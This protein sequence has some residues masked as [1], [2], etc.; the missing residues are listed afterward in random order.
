[1]I[2]IGGHKDL[3][4]KNLRKKL[5]I[6]QDFRV[7]DCTGDSSIFDGFSVEEL[8]TL[9][10]TDQL[11]D[12]DTI[13][14]IATRREIERMEEARRNYFGSLD[15]RH[16]TFSILTAY[17]KKDGKLNIFIVLKQKAYK[18]LGKDLVD[19]MRKISGNDD[20]VNTWSEIEDDYERALTWV[21][22]D[23][24]LADIKNSVKNELREEEEP[25]TKYGWKHGGKKKYSSDGDDDD[26]EMN[27]RRR[28][29]LERKEQKKLLKRM[30]GHNYTIF[31]DMDRVFGFDSKTKSYT[32]DL[33]D[34]DY[35]T[36]G[37]IHKKKKKKNWTDE[38]P[39]FL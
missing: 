20:I 34:A 31:D 21:P 3:S 33:L 17:L 39:K 12:M 9:T 6:L 32:E 30:L 27:E 22:N 25:V 14:H 23:S 7:M 2:V 13:D 1:M 18:V 5:V 24:V 15:V 19:L 29:K 26:D 11:Y 16:A 38:K 36:E 35:G 10:P 37:E 4:P 28:R 8:N